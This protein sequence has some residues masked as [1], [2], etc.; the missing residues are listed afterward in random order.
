MSSTANR[1]QVTCLL[2]L[3]PSDFAGVGRLCSD[4]PALDVI[5]PQNLTPVK[6][7]QNLPGARSSGPEAGDELAQRQDRLRPPGQDVLQTDVLSLRAPSLRPSAPPPLQ[8][9]PPCGP[10]LS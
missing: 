10:V 1:V 9:S 3:E 4:L 8:L 2:V 6:Q 5:P 7:S